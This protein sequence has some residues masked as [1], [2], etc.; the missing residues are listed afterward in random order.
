MAQNARS[1]RNRSPGKQM[2]SLAIPSTRASG[3]RDYFGG[4]GSAGLGF[5]G[6]GVVLGKGGTASP[7]FSR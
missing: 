3:A 2:E 7:S 1:Y 5:D 4:D 6:A